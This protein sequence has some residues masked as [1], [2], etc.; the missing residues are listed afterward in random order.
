LSYDSQGEVPRPRA[1]AAGLGNAS[2]QVIGGDTFTQCESN[3]FAPA[4]GSSSGTSI[5][6]TIGRADGVRANYNTP[7]EL[8]T[9]D[10]TYGL[11]AAN[12]GTNYQSAAEPSGTDHDTALPMES[13]VAALLGLPAGTRWV[14]NPLPE[15]TLQT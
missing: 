4:D 15:P 3:W 11:S 5:M 12:V 13:A 6:A 7:S 9:T 14:G 2:G 1:I 10:A 8:Q